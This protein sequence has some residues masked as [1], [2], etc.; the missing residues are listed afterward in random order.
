MTGMRFAKGHG[1]GNDFIVVPDPAGEIELTPELVRRLCDRRTGLG[2]DGVLRIA[3]AA[4]IGETAAVAAARASPASAKAQVS[5]ESATA[6]PPPA[7]FPS[8]Q[9]FMDYRNA[10][11]SVAEM[12][13]NGIRVFTRYLIDAGLAAGPVVAVATRSGDKLVSEQP[14]GQL[15]V[16]MGP[17]VTGAASWA[18][19]AGRKFRGVCVSVGN[20]HL[21]CEVI[22]PVAELDLTE[23]PEAEPGRFPDGVN[24]ELFRL[25][26]RRAMELRV[27]ERGSGLTMSCG[28]G[29]V[30]AVAAAAAMAVPAASSGASDGMATDQASQ[31]TSGAWE[32]AA[33]G[34]APWTVGVPG[35]RLQVSLSAAGAVL[36]GPAVIVAEGIIAPGWLAG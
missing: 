15:S 14:G 35:G 31:D 4:K 22:E 18:V 10:D 19:V 26:G 20:P 23:P 30:A 34:S 6:V 7:A 25:T 5:A 27:Y 21:A 32:P 36:T 29:A 2:A 17:A 9:W 13:G 12:C 28:T 3:P 24:V 8:P 11:G 16:N 33:A 1:T